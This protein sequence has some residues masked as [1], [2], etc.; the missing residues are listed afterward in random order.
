MKK[1]VLFCMLSA[2]VLCSC[3][4]PTSEE[5]T[6]EVSEEILP[7]FMNE[8]WGDELFKKEGE[9]YLFDTD[10]GGLFDET[11][12]VE[13]SK[14]E[15]TFWTKWSG[16]MGSEYKRFTYFL[17]EGAAYPSVLQLV[18]QEEDLR[19]SSNFKDAKADNYE[20]SLEK[21]NEEKVHEFIEHVSM[22]S[23]GN[24]D[25]NREAFE[26]HLW[27]KI[28]TNWK[29]VKEVFPADL[30]EMISTYIPVY[31]GSKEEDGLFFNRIYLN[32]LANED[33]EQLR[34]ELYPKEE[35]KSYILSYENNLLTIGTSSMHSFRLKWD[36][37]KFSLIEK[38]SKKPSIQQMYT[39]SCGET[40]FVA[41]QAYRFKGK[42]GTND[43]EMELTAN[44]VEDVDFLA[45]QGTYN[46]ISTKNKMKVVTHSLNQPFLNKDIVIIRRKNEEI[47]EK[48]FGKWTS[49]CR[50]EGK[51]AHWGSLKIED[52][53]LELE[54]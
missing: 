38:P 8:I 52:F 14:T 20:L 33:A 9:K 15:I 16:T 42:V 21:H 23:V 17:L 7:V 45:A 30:K 28:G 12:L 32:Y 47:R 4:T 6:K 29:N 35:G 37:G 19:G 50:I 22:E 51:W 49:N 11:E 13:K 2:F 39:E 34:T 41:G 31:E 5:K 27:Q 18:R 26:I 10:A 40:R 46:Y 44:A 25:E 53:Y 24:D 48:F 36:N 54:E 43:I 3:N 1:I